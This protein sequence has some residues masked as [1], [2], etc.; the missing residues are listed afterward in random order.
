MSGICQI[1]RLVA[2][3]PLTTSGAPRQLLLPAFHLHAPHLEPLLSVSHILT[4]SP[5]T[6]STHPACACACACTSQAADSSQSTCT[7]RTDV[8]T[9]AASAAPR[10]LHHKRSGCDKA[11]SSCCPKPSEA[12][13]S[14]PRQLLFVVSPTFS[15][16]SC[17]QRFGCAFAWK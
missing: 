14:R 6:Y 15:Y 16:A 12:L 17:Q 9:A 4:C 5:P 1:G 13:P 11:S 10:G 8:G 2:S 3:Q 7:S